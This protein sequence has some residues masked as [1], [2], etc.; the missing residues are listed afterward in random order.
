M[1]DCH[2]KKF[3]MNFFPLTIRSFRELEETVSASRS[4]LFFNN[5]CKTLM[6]VKQSGV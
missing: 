4:N 5:T 3:C 6:T 1:S 2:F